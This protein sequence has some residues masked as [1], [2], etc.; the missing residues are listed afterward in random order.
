LNRNAS[1]T[2]PNAVGQMAGDHVFRQKAQTASCHRSAQNRFG[3]VR[4]FFDEELLRQ[5]NRT[6]TF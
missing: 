3:S 4:L 2:T 5:V 1:T 6:I